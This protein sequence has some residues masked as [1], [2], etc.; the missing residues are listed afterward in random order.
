MALV[1]CGPI[2]STVGLVE[3]ERAIKDA[4]AA[5]AQSKA[6][7]PYTLADELLRKAREEQGYAAYFD[8]FTLAKEAKLQA[9]EAHR[10]TL[11]A[12]KKAEEDAHTQREAERAAAAKRAP[13]VPPVAPTPPPETTP[14]PPAPEPTPARP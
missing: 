11:E 5:G 2:R 13:A 9:E 14:A 4:R 3:A 8:S 10:L 6:P 7:Y 1:G 12:D